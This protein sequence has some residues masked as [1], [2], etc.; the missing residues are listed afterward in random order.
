MALEDS[1]K[2]E[3]SCRIDS[4]DELSRFGS[5]SCMLGCGEVMT[6]SWNRLPINVEMEWIFEFW[7][8]LCLTRNESGFLG[9][10]GNI[11]LCLIFVTQWW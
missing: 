7:D 8:R 9:C 2:N 5:L 4:K 6:I 10:R 1:G 3:R 11:L